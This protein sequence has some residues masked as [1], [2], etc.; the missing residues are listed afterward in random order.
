M[1]FVKQNCGRV[2]MEIHSMQMTEIEGRRHRIDDT[3]VMS[4]RKKQ[5]QIRTE[6]QI[7]TRNINTHISQIESMR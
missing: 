6:I 2:Q 1:I 7:Q 5:I 4:K 3:Q